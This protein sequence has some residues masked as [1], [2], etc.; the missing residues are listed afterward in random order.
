[1]KGDEIPFL[2]NICGKKIHSQFR[3]HARAWRSP[4]FSLFFS[5]AI[6]NTFLVENTREAPQSESEN[7]FLPLSPLPSSTKVRD[8][9]GRKYTTS[10]VIHAPSLEIK[11]KFGSKSKFVCVNFWVV[12]FA[13]EKRAAR[14]FARAANLLPEGRCF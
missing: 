7:A 9:T 1:M 6:K 12:F 14:K 11:M 3:T 4:T 8:S 13:A 10:D 5:G 2:P